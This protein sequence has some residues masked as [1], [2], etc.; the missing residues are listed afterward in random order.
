MV[1]GYSAAFVTDLRKMRRVH[2]VER[3]RVY[4]VL[5]KVFNSTCLPGEKN[6]LDPNRVASHFADKEN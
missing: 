5:E 4:R 6:M 2:T 3:T 1:T